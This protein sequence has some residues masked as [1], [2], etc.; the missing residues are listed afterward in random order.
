MIEIW[1]CRRKRVSFFE[2]AF[3]RN[4]MKK[5]R[6]PLTKKPLHIAI[7]VAL[8]VALAVGMHVLSL[9]HRLQTKVEAV[10]KGIEEWAEDGR[11]PSEAIRIMQ[12]VPGAFK[13]DDVTEAEKDIDEAQ[14]ALN[15]PKDK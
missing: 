2:V 11:D 4:P 8:L 15:V 1:F 13:N 12:Q 9:R 3:S 14:V 7:G 10:Q 6:R 5:T